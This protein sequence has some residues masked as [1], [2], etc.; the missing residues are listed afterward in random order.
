MEERASQE[1]AENYP[2]L[3]SILIPFIGTGAD[4]GDF[5]ITIPLLIQTAI[6]YLNE[7]PECSLDKIYFIEIMKSKFEVAK[8]AFS[9]I[10]C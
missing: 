6:N 1:L 7:N 3:K 4:K 9:K 2:D 10:L 8:N 5:V